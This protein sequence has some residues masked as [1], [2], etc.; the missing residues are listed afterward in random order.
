MRILHAR[1]CPLFCLVLTAFRITQLLCQPISTTPSWRMSA[2][3]SSPVLTACQPRRTC[4]RPI[5]RQSAP[6]GSAP[7][8]R[9]I[10]S[11]TRLDLSPPKSDSPSALSAA[12]SA[13]ALGRTSP[14]QCHWSCNTALL[15]VRRTMRIRRTV[16]RST[17]N[18]FL[19][20]S[21]SL[22]AS[23]LSKLPGLTCAPPPHARHWKALLSDARRMPG[24]SSAK[25][26]I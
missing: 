10:P 23:R 3:L 13:T 5:Y 7:L 2:D 24:S 22:K 8:G 6:S 18:R 17:S 15:L 20:M 14:A 26:L 21:P 1:G 4:H 11:L 9:C 19:A 25:S 16:C 12:L